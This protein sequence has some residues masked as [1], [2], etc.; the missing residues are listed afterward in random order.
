MYVNSL[1]PRE[2]YVNVL[3]RLIKVFFVC[4]DCAPGIAA[5]NATM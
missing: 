1:V 5:Q 3:E 4:V 2:F